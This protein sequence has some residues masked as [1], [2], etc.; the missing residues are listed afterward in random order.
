MWIILGLWMIHVLEE[1]WRTQELSLDL[2]AR[3]GLDAV[4]QLSWTPSDGKPWGWLSK[5]NMQVRSRSLVRSLMLTYLNLKEMVIEMVSMVSMG[6]KNVM[7]LV[8]TFY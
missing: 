6:M 1:F 3:L 2:A 7:V 8:R 5:T 4:A